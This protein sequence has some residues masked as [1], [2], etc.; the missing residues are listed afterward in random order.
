MLRKGTEDSGSTETGAGGGWFMC[1]LKMQ[2]ITEDC[3]FS[4]KVKPLW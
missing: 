4:G 1:A 3:M 2:G